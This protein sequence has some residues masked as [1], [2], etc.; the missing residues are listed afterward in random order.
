MEGIYRWTTPE[1]ELEA[2]KVVIPATCVYCEAVEFSDTGAQL[3][4]LHPDDEGE[5]VEFPIVHV[6]DDPGR[7]PKLKRVNE[8]W[9]KEDTTEML[10]LW[11]KTRL[12][13]FRGHF[14]RNYHSMQVVYLQPPVAGPADMHQGWAVEM[15]AAFFGGFKPEGLEEFE[16]KSKIITDVGPGLRLV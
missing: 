10:K 11:E 2:V 13:Q 16:W 12:E 3:V 15:V 1:D 6:W 14:F 8:G 7:S 5:P 9:E 4:R